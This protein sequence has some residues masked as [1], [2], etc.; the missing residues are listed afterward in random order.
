[1]HPSNKRGFALERAK[2][3]KEHLRSAVS[4]QRR[5]AS[6]V[7]VT[8]S[9]PVSHP[10]ITLSHAQTRAAI[11]VTCCQDARWLV[12]ATAQFPLQCQ[13][14]GRAPRAVER[15]LTRARRVCRVLPFRQGEGTCSRDSRAAECR[16]SGAMAP[17][18]ARRDHGDAGSP[19]D[20]CGTLGCQRLL[21]RPPL[22]RMDA[23]PCQ[24]LDVRRRSAG[25]SPRLIAR[26]L[27]RSDW[28]RK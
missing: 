5:K 8:K 3:K 28:G 7:T 20:L 24:S 25:R 12:S 17:G 21:R 22:I 2:T 23:V 18:R 11:T 6:A 16:E 13:P 26:Q 19:P 1:M 14:D 4:R 15:S 27:V 10:V 9:P